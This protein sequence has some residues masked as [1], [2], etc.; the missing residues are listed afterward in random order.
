[1]ERPGV[2]LTSIR[3]EVEARK[4]GALVLPGRRRNNSSSYNQKKN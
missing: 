3:A 1:M 4:G 2:S